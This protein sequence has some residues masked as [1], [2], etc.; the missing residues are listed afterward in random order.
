MGI[1]NIQYG[2]DS[3]QD[4]R[5]TKMG[6]RDNVET[7]CI[8][9]NIEAKPTERFWTSLCSKYS[10]YG[11][12]PRIFHLFTHREVFDRIHDSVHN[13]G[14]DRLHWAVETDE[15]GQN[16]LLAVCRP[17][18]AILNYEA[19]NDL[20]KQHAL[21]A[22]SVSYNTGI[23]RSEHAP[24]YMAD[25]NIGNDTFS[26]RYVTETP[27]DGYGRPLIYLSLLRQVCSNGAIGYAKAFRSEANLGKNND[28]LSV[29]QRLFDS[30][31]NEEG[32][33]A[34]R[35]RIEAATTSWASIN[36]SRTV[37]E[38]MHRL[39]K[40]NA[41]HDAQDDTN[42]ESRANRYAKEHRLT[43][44]HIGELETPLSIKMNRAFTEL[45]G[46]VVLTYQLANIDALSRKRQSQLP[47]KCTVY[48][49]LNFVTELAT[50]YCEPHGA[51]PLQAI[52]GNMISN[53]YDLEGT[54]LTKT[55]FQDFFISD[56]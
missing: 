13:K 17:D 30:F 44:E 55:S 7:I 27:I 26:Y 16:R 21:S 1:R 52:V 42:I 33:A 31:S 35:Q 56:N 48:D 14:T 3:I 8:G 23:I 34:F 54:K 11:L 28:G 24:P 4:F 20:V 18:A 2:N 49:L 47:V 32:Y 9:D 50:H 22:D 29:L 51:R 10:S 53:E 40:D 12:S 5:V 37:Y 45:T 25:F 39:L 6:E 46:D 15:N 38:T 19:A 43:A 41:I 36:E